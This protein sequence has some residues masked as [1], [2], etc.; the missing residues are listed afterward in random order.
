MEAVRGY[1]DGVNIKPLESIKAKPNQ[2]VI[3]TFVDEIITP[4]KTDS[5]SSLR[6][7]LSEYANPTLV[8]KEEEAWKRAMVKKHGDA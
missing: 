7:V 1:Y 3:I 5:A 6:G 8:S 2:S 4:V